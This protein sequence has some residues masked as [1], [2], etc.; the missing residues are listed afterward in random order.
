[1]MASKADPTVKVAK[2]TEFLEMAE[3]ALADGCYDCAASL[4]VSAGVNAVDGLCLHV[5]GRYSKVQGHEDA[6]VLVSKA[7]VTGR[8]TAT[9]FRR[10]LSH[11]EQ[12]PVCEC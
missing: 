5:I 4:A 6:V 12:I 10:L 1:M 11:Q 7:G 2:A 9:Q 8:T 3:V